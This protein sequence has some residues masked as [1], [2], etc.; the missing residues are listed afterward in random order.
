MIEGKLESNLSGILKKKGHPICK[1]TIS[2]LGKT[3]AEGVIFKMSDY[4]IDWACKKIIEN[5][6]E[7]DKLLHKSSKALVNI[8]K[9]IKFVKESDD[10]D[11][12]SVQ[13]NFF[14]PMFLSEGKVN[15]GKKRY[16]QITID[17]LEAG[18]SSRD[19]FSITMFYDVTKKVVGFYGATDQKLIL[20]SIETS[21][22]V[23]SVKE[24]LK[25]AVKLS[26]EVWNDELWDVLFS[27]K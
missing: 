15:L 9:K 26:Y 21:V 24:A 22:K 16:N 13:I 14:T 19:I 5:K 27:L 8:E 2:F 1:Y 6:N 7:T 3:P 17:F 4:G 18:I 12:K 25:A 23:T 20:P 10:P 11:V